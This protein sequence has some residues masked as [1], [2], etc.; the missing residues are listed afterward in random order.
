MHRSVKYA[1]I[2][3]AVGFAAAPAQAQVEVVPRDSI[4]PH[5]TSPSMP[6]DSLEE[7]V[8][9]VVKRGDTLWDLAKHYLQDPFRWPDVFQR[10]TDVVED[11]H[12]IYPGEVLRIPGTAVR[13]EALRAAQ[14]EGLVVSRVV[15]RP[16]EG[17]STVFAEGMGRQYVNLA[18]I[19]R[20]RGSGLRRGEIDAAPFVTHHRGPAGAGQV[21]GTGERHA[22]AV[23][24]RDHRFQ[25]HEHAYLSAPAGVPLTMGT[26]LMALASG[27][28][29][30]DTTRLMVPTG[31]FR[32]VEQA[33]GPRPAK[34]RLVRQ[35][36]EVFV[37]Q[38]LVAYES[39]PPADNRELEPVASSS[40]ARVMWVHN[41]PVL[42][43]VQHYVIL[44]LPPGGGLSPG[45]RLT[46][47]DPAS[48]DQDRAVTLPEDAA[49]VQVVKVTPHGATAVVLAQ[50]FPTI[51]QGMPAR[52]SARLR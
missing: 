48:P 26:E 37:G 49:L 9:H 45:D 33:S 29:L 22:V 25:L 30:S 39:Q 38:R 17:G 12:W 35:F 24:V 15:T 18:A 23:E 4:R 13:P 52:L 21:I 51:R 10:N 11:P 40:D 31:V 44:S 41:N 6:S 42:P 2:A 7:E 27:T 36:G 8:R 3:A 47:V 1:A 43:S 46:L 50:R 34:A 5:D 28:E 20:A 32:V 14:E 16:A 19:E